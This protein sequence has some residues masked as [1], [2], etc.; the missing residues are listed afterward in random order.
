TASMDA[1]LRVLER[2]PKAP[3]PPAEMERGLDAVT[4]VTNLYC[5]MWRR[6]AARFAKGA[7]VVEVKTSIEGLLPVLEAASP[8][9]GSMLSHARET[10]E[11]FPNHALVGV[12]EMKKAKVEVDGMIG[13]MKGLIELFSRPCKPRTEED[14]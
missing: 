9:L 14:R 5:G 3:L 1:P 4:R 2:K 12:E 10:A 8:L 7:P 6:D 11:H 13:E